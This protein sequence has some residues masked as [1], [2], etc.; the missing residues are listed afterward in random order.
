MARWL[1]NTQMAR[2]VGKRFTEQ[3]PLAV[4][5]GGRVIRGRG[6][7]GYQGEGRGN[8]GFGPGGRGRSMYLTDSLGLF[9][10]SY[11]DLCTK[12]GTV[13]SSDEDAEGESY[14]HTEFKGL[15][16]TKRPFV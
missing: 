5:S 10:I 12:D 8:F 9:E 2:D 16:V 1:Y 3:R 11:E 15:G 6:I 7:G 4:S 13:E 14:L